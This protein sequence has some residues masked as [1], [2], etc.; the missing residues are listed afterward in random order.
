MNRPTVSYEIASAARYLDSKG[1]NFH[2][3]QLISVIGELRYSQTRKK[4]EF[5]TKMLVLDQ[6]EVEKYWQTKIFATLLSSLYFG[7]LLGMMISIYTKREVID[8]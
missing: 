5:D 7:I 6:I 8:E 4:G 1:K 2:H 3:L